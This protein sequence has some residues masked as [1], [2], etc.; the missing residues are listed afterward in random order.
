MNSKKIY[1]K[2]KYQDIQIPF[3]SVPINNA[4]SQDNPF[5]FFLYDTS[6]EHGLKVNLNRKN[7]NGINKLRSNWINDRNDTT[8]KEN[9]SLIASNS[10]N[11][12]Q[13]YYAK[14]RNYYQRNAVYI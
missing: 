4:K 6:G 9:G 10:N 13:M 1:I 11:V 8:K 7:H 3:M 2:S 14:K 5:E 12:S